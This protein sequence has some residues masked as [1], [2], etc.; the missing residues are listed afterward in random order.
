MLHHIDKFKIN[1][2]ETERKKNIYIRTCGAYHDEKN[3]QDEEVTVGINRYLFTLHRNTHT[4]NKENK[5][6]ET[7]R[8][9]EE[10]TWFLK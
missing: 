6:R 2:D 4:Q 10:D 1:D 3:K 7:Q 8:E 5:R 9:G